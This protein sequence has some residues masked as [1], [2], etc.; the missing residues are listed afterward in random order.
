VF[1]GS[2]DLR[3]KLTSASEPAF[4]QLLDEL[5]LRRHP[6]ASETRHSLRR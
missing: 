3:K 2:G 1:F 5:E 6:L 4:L